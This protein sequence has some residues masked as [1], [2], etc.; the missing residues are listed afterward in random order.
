MSYEDYSNP[1]RPEWLRE[2]LEKARSIQTYWPQLTPLERGEAVLMMLEY[3]ISMRG[4]AKIVG[5]SEGTIR[6]YQIIG[7]LTDWSKRDVEEGR[8]PLRQI[9]RSIRQQRADCGG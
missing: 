7:M 4:L 2:Y 6:N 1:E 8:Y 9:V 3:G 5:C